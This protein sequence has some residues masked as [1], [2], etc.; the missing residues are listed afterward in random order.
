MFNKVHF[1]NR[2]ITNYFLI[3][4]KKLYFCNKKAKV[5]EI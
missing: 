1:I 3:L 4:N 2:K 5:G